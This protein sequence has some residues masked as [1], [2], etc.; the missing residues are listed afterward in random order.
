MHRE[1]N[2]DFILKH[3]ESCSGKV[4]PTYHYLD[5]EGVSSWSVFKAG[6]TWQIN[7]VYHENG[8]AYNWVLG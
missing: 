5:L 1:K 4:G 7:A 6:E 8:K 3:R 2:N